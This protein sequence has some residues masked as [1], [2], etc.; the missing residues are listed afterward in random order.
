[1]RL[2]PN[3]GLILNVLPLELFLDM[4]SSSLADRN[5]TR[6]ASTSTLRLKLRAKMLALF[7]MSKIRVPGFLYFWTFVG[8]LKGNRLRRR[9]M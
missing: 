2:V 8:F 3:I 7:Y 1:V 5:A 4:A 9:A 6:V